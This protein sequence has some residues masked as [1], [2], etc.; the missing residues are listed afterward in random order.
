MP[1]RLYHAKI[2]NVVDG[3]TVRILWQGLA[4]YVRIVGLDTDELEGPQ[5]KRAV[6]QTKILQRFVRRWFKPRIIAETG[7]SRE[8]HQFIRHHDGRWLCRVYVWKW[9]RF[10]WVDYSKHMVKTGNV[11]RGSKW[12]G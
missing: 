6:R 12:N 5:H 9:S 8:G 11:K 4:W 7:K 10:W 3:D 1:K 2:V